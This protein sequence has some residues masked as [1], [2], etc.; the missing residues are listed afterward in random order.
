MT[1]WTDL[2]SET[3][4]HTYKYHVPID[5]CMYVWVI[6]SHD[7]MKNKLSLSLFQFY[8]SEKGPLKFYCIPVIEILIDIV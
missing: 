2:Q 5:V 7:T 6:K 1:S 3:E 8:D 4:I